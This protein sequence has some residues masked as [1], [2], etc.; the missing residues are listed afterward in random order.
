MSKITCKYCGKVIEGKGKKIGPGMVYCNN[1]CSVRDA[2]EQYPGTSLAKML[3]K[4]YPEE[5]CRREM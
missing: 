5:T 4:M 1:S 3:E 2:Y